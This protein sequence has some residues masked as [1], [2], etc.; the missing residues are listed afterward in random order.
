MFSFYLL[1]KFIHILAA[2]TA[3]GANITYGVWNAR[4]GRDT[5]H[6]AFALKGIKFIDDRVANPSYGVVLITG[7][8]MVF[9]GSWGF[10]LWIVLALILFAVVA[11]MAVVY[12]LSLR[13]QVRLAVSG[14]ITSSEY[15]RL[16]RRAMIFGIGT[17]VGVALILVMMVFK[18]TL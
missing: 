6:T 16:D 12:S 3:V 17:G 9:A 10:K 1:L 18:P 5:S 15:M 11:A 2:I 14:D 7:L 13:N 8:I 4:V